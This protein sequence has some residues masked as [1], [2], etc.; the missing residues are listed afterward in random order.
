MIRKVLSIVIIIGVLLG[1]YKAVDGD[2]MVV[3]DHV[4][5]MFITVVNFVASLTTPVWEAIFGR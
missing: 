5:T 4:V 2:F 1:L 3:I